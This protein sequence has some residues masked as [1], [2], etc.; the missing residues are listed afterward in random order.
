MSK[1]KLVLIMCLFCVTLTGCQSGNESVSNSRENEK[2]Y[3]FYSAQMDYETFLRFNG[4][5]EEKDFDGDGKNDYLIR[6]TLANTQESVYYI[7]FSEKDNP[8]LLGAF[9]QSYM[10]TV[11]CRDIDNDGR[12]EL[13]SL[14][15]DDHS[16]NFQD[17]ATFEIY[18]Q[19]IWPDEIYWDSVRV[20]KGEQLMDQGL[21]WTNPA[22]YMKKS[23]F[24]FLL[25]EDV[26]NYKISLGEY[27]HTV[28]EA[29]IVIPESFKELV[30]QNIARP[31]YHYEISENDPCTMYLY[32]NLGT[33]Q[34]NIGTVVTTIKWLETGHY[35]VKD[36]SIFESENI[37]TDEMLPENTPDEEMQQIALSHRIIA[38][39]PEMDLSLTGRSNGYDYMDISLHYNGQ[40]LPI[41]GTTMAGSM[42]MPSLV[43][44]ENNSKAAIILIESEGSGIY[45]SSIHIVDLEEFHEI[46]HE[47]AI[48]YISQKISSTVDVETGIVN[49]ELPDRILQFDTSDIVSPTNLFDQVGY[50]SIVKYYI[51]NDKI[52][53]DAALHIAPGSDLGYVRLEYCFMENEYTVDRMEFQEFSD[54]RFQ[55]RILEK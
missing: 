51:E 43:L 28:E 36:I 4:V 54:N 35:E 3:D 20:P 24:D 25:L 30:N 18:K 45:I 1:I 19:N 22:A 17:T 53:C 8:L 21:D 37:S 9:P 23:G 14:G 16:Y 31:I 11:E 41:S 10:L 5:M 40:M 33:S 42:F 15:V 50:G 39:I 7:K 29:P 34:F 26:D 32:Q 55:Y 12:N 38:D 27:G 49:L 13:I 6:E 47:D 44:F 52:Y 46:S 48:P 2:Q